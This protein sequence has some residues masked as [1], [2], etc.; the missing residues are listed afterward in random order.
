MFNDKLSLAHIFNAGGIEPFD[1]DEHFKTIRE[2]LDKY[3]EKRKTKDPE[4]DPSTD[5]TI[6]TVIY[7][8]EIISENPEAEWKVKVKHKPEVGVF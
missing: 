6:A 2:N 8:F 7:A 4:F 3:I 1:I 5:M